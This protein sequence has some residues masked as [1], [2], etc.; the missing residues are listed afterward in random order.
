MEALWAPWRM[1]FIKG[2]RPDTCVFC[3][4]FKAGKPDRERLVLHVGPSA[5]IVMNRFPYGH[6]H[7]LVM[8]RR[9]VAAITDLS[10]EEN[11]EIMDLLQVSAKVLA[12]AMAPQGF[13]AGLNLG[14]AAGAGIEDHLHWHFLPR[15]L[16]DVNFLTLVGEL[17]SI[18]EHIAVTYDQLRPLFAK[19]FEC[20]P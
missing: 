6:G 1:E 16:G 8:P 12:E 10:R 13:N 17:R 4:A 18:P 15:W 2:K 20:V 14:R 11:A 19:R 3:D 5:G 7:L 9:H